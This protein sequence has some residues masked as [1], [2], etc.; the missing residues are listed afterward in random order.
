LGCEKLIFSHGEVTMTAG[1][2]SSGGSKPSVEKGYRDGTIRRPTHDSIFPS[3]PGGGPAVNNKNDPT[4]S[5]MQPIRREESSGGGSE[6][7]GK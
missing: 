3:K 5:R 2:P 4:V 6:K 1:R 7:Q